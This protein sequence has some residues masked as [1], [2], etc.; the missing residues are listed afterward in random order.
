MATAMSMGLYVIYTNHIGRGVASTYR[1]DINTGVFWRELPMHLRDTDRI[2]IVELQNMEDATF[3]TSENEARL[4]TLTELLQKHMDKE[5]H[6][7]FIAHRKEDFISLMADRWAKT[8]AFHARF[9]FIYDA[10]RNTTCEIAD[11]CVDNRQT[12][13]VR[14]DPSNPHSCI[15][16]QVTPNEVLHR[17]VA[18]RS[19]NTKLITKEE[20]KAAR[21]YN[22]FIPLNIM[23]HFNKTYT[24]WVSPYGD[25]YDERDSDAERDSDTE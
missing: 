3:N 22:P 9:D 14:L 18:S 8:P 15:E 4:R 6:S 10:W 21:G 23:R 1:A 11:N 16:L 7:L 25:T 19:I 24:K 12:H 2:A 17:H 13:T 20:K 5:T